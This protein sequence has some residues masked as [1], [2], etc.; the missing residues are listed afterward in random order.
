M[1]RV[2]LEWKKKPNGHHVTVYEDD[3]YRIERVVSTYNSPRDHPLWVLTR[4][5]KILYVSPNAYSNLECVGLP[6][7]KQVAAAL[8]GGTPVSEIK[9]EEIRN[10]SK[11]VSTKKPALKGAKTAVDDAA[12]DSYNGKPPTERNQEGLTRITAATKD[13]KY[14]PKFAMENA[15]FSSIFRW[16]ERVRNYFEARGIYATLSML[17]GFILNREFDNY[18]RKDKAVIR[19]NL[20]Y[21]EEREHDRVRLTEMVRVASIPKETAVRKKVERDKFGSK[22]GSAQ[23]KVNEHLI[24]KFRSHQR[25]LDLAGLKDGV[26]GWLEE[27]VKKGLVRRKTKIVNGKKRVKYALVLPNAPATIKAK[28]TEIKKKT[29]SVKKKRDTVKVGKGKRRSQSR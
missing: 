13:Q 5:K 27:L 1:T 15:K 8:A 2:K 26:H 12:V 17:R 4:D 28:K 20:I 24:G 9:K 21:A 11:P 14:P 7:C 6:R 25:L 22:I 10:G 29:V 18:N 23:A 3:V 19:L 16:S